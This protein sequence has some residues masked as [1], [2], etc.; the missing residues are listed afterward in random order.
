MTHTERVS[1]LLSEKINEW[2]KTDHLVE[3]IVDCFL[4]LMEMDGQYDID[5]Q[6]TVLELTADRYK[7]EVGIVHDPFIRE[8]LMYHATAIKVN[9]GY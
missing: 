1:N 5:D 7:S 9:N 8:V 6:I 3:V 2:G 4:S